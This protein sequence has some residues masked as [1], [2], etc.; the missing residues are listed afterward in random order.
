MKW[1]SKVNLL[2]TKKQALDQVLWR[3]EDW[4]LAIN[5]YGK[6]ILLRNIKRVLDNTH[7]GRRNK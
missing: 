6:P 3:R 2:T 4:Q 1:D 7:Y 5:V